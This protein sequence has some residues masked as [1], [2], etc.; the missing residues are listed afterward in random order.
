MV[1]TSDFVALAVGVE[2]YVSTSEKRQEE[3]TVWIK[4]SNCLA[5]RTTD[6]ALCRFVGDETVKKLDKP[7]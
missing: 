3:E 4:V 2:F 6:H 7:E 5:Y 1:D